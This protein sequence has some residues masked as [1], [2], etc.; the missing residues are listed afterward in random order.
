MKPVIF[1]GASLR[2]LKDFPQKARREAGFQIYNV[3]S[4]RN[5]DDWKSVKTVGAGVIEIRIHE[6]GEFR[7]ILVAKFE[8]AIYILHAF[9]K[10]SQKIPKKN[11]QLAKIRYEQ[12]LEERKRY[13]HE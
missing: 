7:V 1:I 10:K 12:V 11:I 3:Q 2:D 4:G 5:P 6:D 8:E 9:Q 13:E